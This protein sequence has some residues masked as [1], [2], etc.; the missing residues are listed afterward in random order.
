MLVST[1]CTVVDFVT[2]K[3]VARTEL[4]DLGLHL[5]LQRLEPCEFVHPTGQA[6][7]VVD[8]QRTQRGVALRGGDPGVAVHVV[9]DRDRNVLHSLTV[10]QFLCSCW[11]QR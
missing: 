8:D 5:V 1:N 10:T 9:R 3:P 6:F 4:G 2:V 11:R 7:E